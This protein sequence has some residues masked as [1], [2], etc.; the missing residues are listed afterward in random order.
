MRWSSAALYRFLVPGSSKVTSLSSTIIQ[1]IVLH[2]FQPSAPCSS[3]PHGHPV[4]V[5]KP[6][7]AT[8]SLLYYT[9]SKSKKMAR[10]DQGNVGCQMLSHLRV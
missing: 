5:I 7:S 10:Y 4:N 6:F 8:S 2:P 9:P 3:T 1:L